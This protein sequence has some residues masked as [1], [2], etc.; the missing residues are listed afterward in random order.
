MANLRISGDI[1]IGILIVIQL[2][3]AFTCDTIV[4]C[5]VRCRLRFWNYVTGTPIGDPIVDHSGSLRSI[6]A[7]S[8]IGG[9]VT[10]SNDGLCVVFN[11]YCGLLAK[12]LGYC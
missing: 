11:G 3:R 6:A 9:L 1:V 4:A 5:I 10:T 7:V 12:V 2:W 8:G